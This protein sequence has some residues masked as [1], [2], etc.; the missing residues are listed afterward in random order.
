[1]KP[2]D[3]KEEINADYLIELAL[4]ED[5][6][7]KISEGDITSNATISKTKIIKIQIRVKEHCVLCGMILVKRIIEIYEKLAKIKGKNK[8][9]FKTL[10][11]DGSFMQKNE[12]VAEIS[13]NA[14]TILG[15]ERTILNFLA[16]LSGV[17]TTTNKFVERVLPYRVQLLDTRKT[18]AGYREL[19]KYAVRTGGGTNHRKGLYDMFLVKDNHIAADGNLRKTIEQIEKIK[20]NNRKDKDKKV[21]VEIESLQQLDELLKL[22]KLPDWVMLDNLSYEEME[23]GVERLR[24]KSKELKKDVKIEASGGVN[25]Q[26]ISEV[27]KCGVDYISVGTALTLGAKPID[28]CIDVIV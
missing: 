24:R 17:A 12:K 8:V 7:N 25:L 18:I 11:K 19:E 10:R 2:K 27:A 20:K 6:G 26:N 22:K 16:V 15:V 14:R 9:K 21:E 28:F 3:S 13:G 4:K 1:M 5:L 23:I